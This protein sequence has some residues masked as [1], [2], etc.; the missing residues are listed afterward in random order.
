MSSYKSSQIKLNH[1]NKVLSV[2]VTNITGKEYWP[3]Q[4]GSGDLWYSGS[5]SK[6]YY[7]W[8]VTFTVTE[9][10]H[11]SHLTRDDFKYNGLDIVVG[12]WIAGSTSGQAL[13]IISISAKT[14]TSVTC[15]IEDWLRYNT[16]KSTTGNGIFN[17]GSAVVFTLNENGLPMLDPLPTSVSSSFYTEVFSRFQYLN[18]QLNYVL[19]KTAHGFS[20]GDVIAVTADSGFVKANSTTADRMIGVVTESGPGPDYFMVLPNNRIIDFDPSIPGSTGEFIYV[21]TDGTLSNVDTGTSKIAFL[22]LQSAVATVLTGS[23]ANPSIGD[24]NAIVLNGTSIT[25]SGTAGISNVTEIKNQINNVTANTFVV[26]DVLPFENVIQG[27]S[28]NTIYSLIG[29][30]VPFSAYFDTGSGNTLIN[31]TAN[32]SVYPTV[33]TPQDMAL[34]IN[35]A[36]I[37][38][39]NATATTTE[40]TITELNG[41]AI[42][43]SNGNAETG[44]YYFVGASNISGL[45]EYTAATSAEKLQLTRSDGGEILIYEDS[46]LFQTETG[47]FSAHTGQVPL[48]MNIEQGVRTGVTTVVGTISAR[49]SLIPAAG[50]QAYVANKGDGEWGLY[51]YTG[52]AWTLISNADSASTDAKTLTTT[53]T[54]PVGGFGNSSTTTLGN[55]SPG[56]KITTVSVEVDTAFS[57]Y[58]GNI[59]PNIEIG[60]AADPDIFVDDVSNDLTEASQFFQFPEYLYPATNTQDIV[61][62]ARC[63]HYQSTTGNVTIK[64]TYV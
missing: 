30:Y 12:D 37:A 4:N 21:H 14:K 44:G 50:D 56:R 34:D 62:R 16:F 19:E 53:F 23:E 45:P 11:G 54:M 28:A 31:F 52:S 27:D 48:A 1:P 42:I 43:I 18:P 15:T 38:N 64:L 3:Y 20:K 32:G 2:S 33:S 8:E 61:V 47:I 22:N 13:K 40:L 29:G 63:N 26:A 7:R 49:D 5:I 59:L 17:T 51:L 24:G 9:Q 36:N 25:F 46:D 60:T 35:N 10:L 58:Q 57:G 41:N 39:L 6:R 55:I